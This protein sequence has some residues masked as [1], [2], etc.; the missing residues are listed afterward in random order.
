M[1]TDA[2]KEDSS[3]GVRESQ[4]LGVCV[5][6]GWSRKSKSKGELK[7]G[8][9]ARS[10]GNPPFSVQCEEGCSEGP[11]ILSPAD[12]LRESGHES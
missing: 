2:E 4:G 1:R 9:H 8:F 3:D 7:F 6:A 10:R 5:A 12:S 11:L